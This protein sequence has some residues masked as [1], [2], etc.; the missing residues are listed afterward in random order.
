MCTP[1]QTDRNREKERERH[2][3]VWL[4]VYNYYLYPQCVY[5]SET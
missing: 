5:I 2:V 1:A 4:A 3:C